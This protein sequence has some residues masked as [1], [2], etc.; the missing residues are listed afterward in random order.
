M[1]PRVD[2]VRKGLEEL[3]DLSEDQADLICDVFQILNARIVALLDRDHQI[4][5]SYFL[6][7]SSV[8]A[9]GESLYRRVFPLLQEYFYNDYERLK[10]LLGLYD[11][12]KGAGFIERQSLKYGAGFIRDDEDEEPWT[13]HRY[14]ASE[15]EAALRRTFLGT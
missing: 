3:P 2:V 4:G 10:R 15:L 6:G 1:M 5:H 13:F 14:E 12:D 8:D 9:L 7:I 11:A